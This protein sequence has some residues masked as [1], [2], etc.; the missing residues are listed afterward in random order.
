MGGVKLNIKIPTELVPNPKNYTKKTSLPTQR[1]VLVREEILHHE[2]HMKNLN[3][4]KC[5]ICLE[6]H[7]MDGHAQQAKNC[8]PVKSAAVERIPCTS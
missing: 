6:L 8:F 3:I 7:I 5:E 4:L 1:S 2:Y